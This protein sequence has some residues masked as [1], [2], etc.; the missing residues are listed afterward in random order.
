M[1]LPIRH[2]HADKPPRFLYC[3]ARIYA[4]LGLADWTQTPLTTSSATLMPCLARHR[5]LLLLLAHMSPEIAG[6][7]CRGRT[8]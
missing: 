7:I 6:L 3:H 2:G 1:A 4:L 8:K 5:G